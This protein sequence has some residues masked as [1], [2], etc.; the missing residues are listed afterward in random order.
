MGIFLSV[1]SKNTWKGQD[2]SRRVPVP[3]PPRAVGYFVIESDIGPFIDNETPGDWMAER[4][5]VVFIIPKQGETSV[6]QCI[7]R[8]QNDP[9]FL[10]RQPEIV[11]LSGAGC[12][13]SAFNHM[14]GDSG[15]SYVV[16]RKQVSKLG[17]TMK[18]M[19]DPLSPDKEAT[20]VVDLT[21]LPTVEFMVELPKAL[22]AV[23]QREV[24]DAVY[25]GEDLVDADR[26][27]LFDATTPLD[28]ALKQMNARRDQELAQMK[29][30]R[31]VAEKFMQQ[32]A[33]PAAAPAARSPQEPPEM[34]ELPP[35]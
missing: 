23:Y 3:L 27:L 17:M 24:W 35:L 18:V 25:T 6:A 11:E 21:S 2:I 14:D 12:F 19:Q 22:A 16:F 32:P 4:F 8:A 29:R 13:S 28:A 30:D 1:M 5:I 33:K 31:I 7:W 9:F 26:L 15:Y 20:E 10:A 34:T